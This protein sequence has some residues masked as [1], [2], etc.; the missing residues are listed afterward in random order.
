MRVL[1]I[2]VQAG[3]GGDN[4]PIPG[5]HLPIAGGHLQEGKRGEC[6][7]FFKKKNSQAISV[8]M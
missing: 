4:C 7:F 6:F 2:K 3:I 8:P 1:L 5:R